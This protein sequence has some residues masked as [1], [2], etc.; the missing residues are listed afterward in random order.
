MNDE[1]NYEEV[2]FDDLWE[3]IGPLL[4]AYL[5]TGNATLIEDISKHPIMSL[6]DYEAVK[7]VNAVLKKLNKA[8]LNTNQ[9]NELTKILKDT[10][11]EGRVDYYLLYQEKVE[12]FEDGKFGCIAFS[13]GEWDHSIETCLCKIED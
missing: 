8:I 12:E 13:Y 5:E 11:E 4:T 7:F 3:G 10:I 1:D 6:Y 9:W 2:F